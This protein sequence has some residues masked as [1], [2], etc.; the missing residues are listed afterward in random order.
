MS[1]INK[2]KKALSSKEVKNF[3]ESVS[4]KIEDIK[5]DVSETA[6][7]IDKKY[8]ISEKIDDVKEKVSGEYSELDKKYSIT[9]KIEGIKEK[10]DEIAE[11]AKDEIVDL[12]EKIESKFEGKI[13]YDDFVKVEMKVGKIISA[14]KIKKSDKLMLLKV[15]IGEEE[16]RQIVSGIS[17][18]F[19][20][21]SEYLKGKQALFVTNLEPRTIFGYESNGMIIAL[22]DNEHSTLLQPMI[23]I[24]NGT[25]AG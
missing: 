21:P 23:E 24:K 11:N 4:E 6:K 25:K 22:T 5:E 3:K 20:N 15:D 14:E 2:I 19:D 9:G 18:F 7:K 8:D 1:F 12:K 17:K 16:P 13:S 10:A